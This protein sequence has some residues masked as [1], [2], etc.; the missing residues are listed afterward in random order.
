METK[1]SEEPLFKTPQTVCCKEGV[2]KRELSPTAA[3][4]VNW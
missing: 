4:D 3:E 2:S 1:L